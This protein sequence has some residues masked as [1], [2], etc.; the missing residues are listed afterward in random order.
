M[1]AVEADYGVICVIYDYIFVYVSTIIYYYFQLHAVSCIYQSRQ[2]NS[3]A[4]TL[5]STPSVEF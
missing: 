5:H 1:H 4:N 2:R 3:S